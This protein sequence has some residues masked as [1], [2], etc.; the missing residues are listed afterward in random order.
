MD[1]KSQL[2]RIC[3]IISF[4][5]P[6]DSFI[7]QV[8]EQLQRV[9]PPQLA[10]RYWLIVMTGVVCLI[11]FMTKGLSSSSSSLTPYPPQRIHLLEELIQSAQKSGTPVQIK[12]D[13]SGAMSVQ[14]GFDSIGAVQ[15]IMNDPTLE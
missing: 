15:P 14:L 2:I 8:K 6:L 3:L 10:S 4:S 7:L 5:N 9:F 11:W 12:L 1:L 13:G